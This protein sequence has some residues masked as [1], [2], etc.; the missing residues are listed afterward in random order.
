MQKEAEKEETLIDRSID[1]PDKSNMSLK[2]SNYGSSKLL[3]LSLARDDYATGRVQY[4][5]DID[6][7]LKIVSLVADRNPL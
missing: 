1:R 7:V 6:L 5:V 4:S 2:C 3:L